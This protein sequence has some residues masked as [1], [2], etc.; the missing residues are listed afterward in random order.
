[1]FRR[2]KPLALKSSASALANNLSALITPEKDSLNYAVVHKAV[3]NIISSTTDGSS[4]TNKQVICKEPSATHQTTPMILQ[5][6]WIQLPVRTVLVLTTLRG[7]Q[8]YEYDGSAMIYFHALGNVHSSEASE[9][10]NF[11]R[12]ISCVG[13]N[14]LCVGTQLGEIAVFDIPQKGP[15]INMKE[16]LTGH[17]YPVCDLASE[18]NTLISSDEQGS[19]ILWSLNDTSI[20]Q[21]QFI[22]GSGDPCSCLCI[23][24]DIIVGGFGNGQL[25][26]YSAKTGRLAALVNAHVRWI[27]ALDIASESGELLS[28]SDDTYARIWKLKAGE[29]PEIEFSFGESV[30]DLQ[31]CGGQFVHKAGMG[32]CVTGYDSSDLVF[33][34]RN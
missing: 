13:D 32:F 21:R 29:N 9:Y 16:S 8:I 12:G 34:L 20:R 14:F 3:V 22:Q 26:V 18:R 4:V 17:K 1:M 24:K 31:L 10:G 5:C 27:N 25:K 7:I 6:K 15:N 11:G 19:I 28:V 23:W 30:T 33:Y 2:E